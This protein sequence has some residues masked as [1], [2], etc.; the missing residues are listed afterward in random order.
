MNTD[1]LLN[2]AVAVLTLCALVTTGL[3]ARRE[4][5]TPWTAPAP[6]VRIPDWR[7]F[8]REGHRMGPAEAPV[9]VVVFSDFQCSFCAVLM[10][11]LRT[12]REARPDE[13]SV[14]YRHFPIEGHQHAAPAARASEC[15]AE[16]GR[17]EPFHDA[18]FAA[19][20][21]IGA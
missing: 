13:V 15:A 3:V 1:R 16:Q 9:T 19:Q 12:I 14:V 7:S 18:L 6:G 20:D 8:T 4:L 2:V 21:S 17:F 5:S 10:D 11:R